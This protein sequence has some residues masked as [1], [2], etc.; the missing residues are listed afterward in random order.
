MSLPS[1]G[2]PNTFGLDG[3]DEVGQVAGTAKEAG[4]ML[5]R[6]RL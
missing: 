2:S 1:A 5:L 4:P 6:R 3:M